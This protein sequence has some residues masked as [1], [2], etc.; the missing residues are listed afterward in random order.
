MHEINII[1]LACAKAFFK[2]DNEN[3]SR[4]SWANKNFQV[5]RVDVELKDGPL[6]LLRIDEAHMFH[7]PNCELLCHCDAINIF[8]K[9]N[10]FR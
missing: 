2:Q 9:Y 10:I 4:E 6:N 1:T 3:G 7:S 8:L 5:H